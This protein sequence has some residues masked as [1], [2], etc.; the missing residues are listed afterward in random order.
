MKI[1][2]YM[3]LIITVKQNIQFRFGISFTTKQ[4]WNE[5]LCFIR[6]C[7]ISILEEYIH[8]IERTFETE[9]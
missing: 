2:L 1:C 8:R 3:L 6:R 4:Y 7:I 5:E 9:N